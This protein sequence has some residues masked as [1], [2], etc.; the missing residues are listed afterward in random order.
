MHL[1]KGDLTNIPL[2]LQSAFTHVPHQR[3]LRKLNGERTFKDR[4]K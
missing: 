4:G 3:F 2:D 1:D